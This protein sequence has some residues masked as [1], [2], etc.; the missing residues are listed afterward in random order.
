MWTVKWTPEA[1]AQFHEILSFWIENNGSPK[2]SEKIID[3]V[4]EIITLLS[5]SPFLG[6]EYELISQPLK[7]RKVVVLHNF[8]MLYRV[9]EEVEI[10][11]FW[12]NRR[13]PKNL[14]I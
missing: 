4:E 7:I 6:P 13:D 1:E 12:D 3:R 2:Y 5:F 11:S 14:K 8:S 10:V 9:T